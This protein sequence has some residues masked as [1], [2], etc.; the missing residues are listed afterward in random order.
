MISPITHSIPG[1]PRILQG[2][3][4]DRG[5]VDLRN[6]AL[7]ARPDKLALQLSE[8]SQ[9]NTLLPRDTQGVCG[10]SQMIDVVTVDDIVA[11]EGISHLDLLKI[12]VQGWEM[13]VLRG[14]SKLIADHDLIFV[15]AEVAFR[16]DATEMQ[17]FGELHDH[18]ER[19]G[20]AL[21]GFYESVR[22]GPR[23]EFLSFANA[24]YIHP[25]ARLKWADSRAA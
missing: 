10:S 5:N 3:F 21:S 20:F 24:L 19:N 9:L 14:A 11:A 23:K 17:L 1:R 2:N 15:L 6:V 18:L 4:G 8:D 13:E 12:D 16:S 25:A 22:F 7:G